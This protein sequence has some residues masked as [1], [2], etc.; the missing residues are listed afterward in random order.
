MSTEEVKTARGTYI[1]GPTRD[2]NEDW[3]LGEQLGTPGQFGRAV[4]ATR[5]R[6]N[7]DYAIKIICK[8]KFNRSPND[9]DKFKRE[10]EIMQR[11][12][13]KN[14]IEFHN[15]YEDKTNVYIVMELCS[16]GELFDRIKAKG[17]YSER[18]ASRVLRQLFEAIAHMHERKVAHCDLK[19]DNFLFVT[20]A[21]DAPI[22]VIDFGLSKFMMHRRHYYHQFCGT[23]YY[24]APDVLNERYNEAC[25]LW[26]LGVVMFIMLF[27]YPPFYADPKKYGK[28]T[29]NEIFRLIQKGFNP[30]VKPGY[31]AHFPAALSNNVSAAA[32]DLITKLL[33]PSAKRLTADEALNHSWLKQDGSGASTEPLDP[34]VLEGLTNFTGATRFRSAVLKLMV[35]QLS[36]DEMDNLKT[37]FVAMD[38]DKDGVITVNEL[39][40]ALQKVS[41]ETLQKVASPTHS[42]LDPACVDIVKTIM[43]MADVDGNGVLS[44]EEICIAYVQ[45]KLN[46]KE[47]RLWSAFSI[48][49]EDRDGKITIDELKHALSQNS[50]EA[51]QAQEVEKMLKEA[52]ADGN[53]TIDYEEFLQMMWTLHSNHLAT[54]REAASK[55]R[56]EAKGAPAAPPPIFNST[57]K[58]NGSGNG[59]TQPSPVRQGSSGGQVRPLQPKPLVGKP[60]LGVTA[61]MQK[62]TLS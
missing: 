59:S 61:G 18:D 53:G 57:A 36:P 38:T 37:T 49:D 4:R 45:R 6:D 35:H 16:G 40:D 11:L 12:S 39:R 19:P 24:I 31:G 23:P 33:C 14:I 21:D 51:V 43:E 7:A 22:K 29:D 15:V 54:L 60:K 41:P 46:A 62:M 8:A 32:K 25:D 55:H 26:S 50:D 1:F 5:R 58:T 9:L 17:R 27:G 28:D 56:V 13:H 47:E 52:D 2:V 42:G 10:V 20:G 3:I 48:I 34:L 30:V 44:Y